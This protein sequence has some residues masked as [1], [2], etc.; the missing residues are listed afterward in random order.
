MLP[1]KVP[2]I[3]VLI[4]AAPRAD[5]GL[6]LLS[7]VITIL[8]DDFSASADLA[9]PVLSAFMVSLAISQLISEPLSDRFDR[10]KIL[11]SGTVIFIVGGIGA[12]L[13]TT[14][15]MLIG[16]RTL[17]G[18]GTAAYMTMG[19]VIVNDV[20]Q[21][22]EA[23]RTLSIVSS[24]QAIVPPIEFAFGGVIA[25]FIGWRGGIGIMA[26]GGLLIAFMSYL[27]VGESRS[28]DPVLFRPAPLINA[29]LA[30][31]KTSGVMFHGLTSGLAVGMFFAMGGA[32]PHAFDRVGIGPLKYGLFF[33]STSIGFILGNFINGLPVEQVG[34]AWIAYLGSLLTALVPML[35]LAGDLTSLLTLLLLS[36]LCFSFG[37]CNRLVIANAM[38][39]SIRAI[40]SMRAAGRNSG[41][42]TGLLGTMQML[43]GGVVVS[44]IIALGGA[45]YFS[46]TAIGLLIITR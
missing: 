5:L 36:F 26:M 33:A 18:A 27:F 19:R 29:Y 1:I 35:M 46:V 2:P 9:Q 30:L 3:G 15:D 42:G 25:E 41:V 14:I 10:K 7:P 8:W 34:V 37:V 32:M 44:A 28:G 20:Y 13:S 17:Q 23:A 38:I 24:A 45:D 39:Y 31:L 22:V 16:F 12:L 6:S 4:L 43:F 21:G 11:H 40:C